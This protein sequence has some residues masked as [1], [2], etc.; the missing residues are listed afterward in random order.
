MNMDQPIALTITS[1]LSSRGLALQAIRTARREALEGLHTTLVHE[2]RGPL[3]ALHHA[4]NAIDIA[5]V[6]AFQRDAQ[7]VAFI[8]CGA[9]KRDERSKARDLYVGASVTQAVRIADAIGA[10]VVIVSAKHGAIDGDTMIYPYEQRAPRPGGPAHFEWSRMVEQQLRDM[11]IDTA[12][13]VMFAGSSYVRALTWR[14]TASQWPLDALC[15]LQLGERLHVLS[16]LN[17]AIGGAL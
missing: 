2:K 16:K 6:R 1:P 14:L 3:H 9:A 17:R 10:R 15:G 5:A 7:L 12:A 13:S 8:A 4:A 11:Q